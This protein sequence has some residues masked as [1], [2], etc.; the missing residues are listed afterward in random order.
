MFVLPIGSLVAN[1]VLIFLGGALYK[2]D[3]ITNS[4]GTIKFFANSGCLFCNLK[5]MS[6]CM[7]VQIWLVSPCQEMSVWY[8]HAEKWTKCTL[9]S[10]FRMGVKRGEKSMDKLLLEFYK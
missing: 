5:W 1:S 4:V 8:L 9:E 7:Y 6:L 2:L 3:L 10:Q